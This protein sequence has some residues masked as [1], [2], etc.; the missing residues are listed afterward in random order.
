MT[1]EHLASLLAE[2]VM[3]WS[4]GPDRFLTG[5]RG[6]IP[7]WR[8][9]PSEKLVDAFRLLEQAAPDEYSLCVDA[10]GNFQATVTIAG[11]TGEAHG[12]SKARVI[13][14]AVARAVGIEV[15]P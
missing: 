4:V 12:V 8:F 3:G 9:Q 2:R 7:R 5:N 13:T 1:S 10:K 14:C 6:W 11:A 15:E